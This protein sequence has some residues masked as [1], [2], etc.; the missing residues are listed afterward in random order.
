[1]LPRLTGWPCGY[2]P[3]GSAASPA[4]AGRRPV[5]VTTGAAHN[6]ESSPTPFAEVV[7]G[8]ISVTATQALHNETA[9]S[10]LLFT[11]QFYVSLRNEPPFI[12]L[13][14]G[15]LPGF[16]FTHFLCYLFF[17]FGCFFGR[18]FLDLVLKS[19]WAGGTSPLSWPGSVLSELGGIS[20]RQMSVIFAA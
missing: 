5:G 16:R 14:L 12:R 2:L 20:C 3:Q 8:F 11:A 15:G 10:I 7:G 17:F 9:E 19:G 18:G 4:K 1:M 13:L 6:S